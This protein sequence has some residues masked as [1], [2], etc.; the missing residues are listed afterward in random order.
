VIFPYLPAMERRRGKRGKKSPDGRPAA[1][2]H[3]SRGEN[4]KGEIFLVSLPLGR[5]K[6]PIPRGHPRQSVPSKKGRTPREEKRGACLGPLWLPFKKG[7]CLRVP[8]YWEGGGKKGGPPKRRFFCLESGRKKKKGGARTST[9][10]RKR[11]K[12]ACSKMRA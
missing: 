2:Q 3:I 4:K 6:D 11:G 12:P 1:T 7:G 10:R 9:S 8:C 5:G